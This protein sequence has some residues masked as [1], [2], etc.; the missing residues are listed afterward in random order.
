MRTEI[1]KVS[2]LSLIVV[3]LI[4]VSYLDGTCLSVSAQPE[5]DLERMLDSVDG[6]PS[7]GYGM[8]QAPNMMPSGTQGPMPRRMLLPRTQGMQP[9][10]QGVM[11]RSMMQPGMSGMPMQ[12]PM[13]QMMPQGVMQ[14]SM[15]QP[16]M[17]QGMMQPGM[18]QGM[19]NGEYP[20]RGS[21]SGFGNQGGMGGMGGMFS[22][23]KILQ[24]LF[25]GDEPVNPNDPNYASRKQQAISQAQYEQS[26][27]NSKADYA[28]G[29]EGRAKYG[30][31]SYRMGA[32]S[33]ARSAANE[34]RAA[35]D[36]ARSSANGFPDASGYADRA[37]YEADRADAAANRA[38][39]SAESAPSN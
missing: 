29:C 27:A 37:Q 16:G 35:A 2:V 11:Q 9:M 18:Q 24:T 38:Y 20:A 39:S 32:A 23:R 19:M 21:F 15:M 31:R 28:E 30:E 5:S 36:R 3:T 14:R 34:A 6:T 1:K 17:Q 8:Q 26:I 12:G 22:K 25:G 10:P 4:N 33:E 13:Q 7:P